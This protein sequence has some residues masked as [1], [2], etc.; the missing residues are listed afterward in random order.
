MYARGVLHTETPESSIR[1]QGERH[2]AKKTAEL[3]L[4]DLPQRSDWRTEVL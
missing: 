4:S 1:S 2:T 3:T